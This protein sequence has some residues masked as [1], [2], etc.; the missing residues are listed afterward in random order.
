MT[1]ERYIEITK[2]DRTR[3][4][5]QRAAL[6]KNGS[7]M[8]SRWGYQVQFVDTTNG[9]LSELDRRIGELTRIIAIVR[10]QGLAAV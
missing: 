6:L 4:E 10:T 2:A 7:R 5:E 9:W 8:R 1:N 3:L